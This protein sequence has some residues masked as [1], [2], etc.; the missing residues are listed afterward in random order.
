MDEVHH[1]LLV[2]RTL[3]IHISGSASINKQVLPGAIHG[4]LS[5]R[6]TVRPACQSSSRIPHLDD[7]NKG[8]LPPISVEGWPRP[9]GGSYQPSGPP[10]WRW[11]NWFLK[12]RPRKSEV[13]SDGDLLCLASSSPPKN[14][15][16]PPTLV[17]ST[18]IIITTDHWP[19]RS[20]GHH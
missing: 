2:G 1:V 14:H 16:Y 3:S 8:C 11:T 6:Y 17:S 20:G 9:P 18:A 15:P 19:V 5:C 10:L 7:A 4:A 12:H 13:L